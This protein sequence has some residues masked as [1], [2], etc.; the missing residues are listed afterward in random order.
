MDK[1]PLLDAV[2]RNGVGSSTVGAGGGP[3]PVWSAI[4]LE[5]WYVM[6]KKVKYVVLSLWLKM[7]D[8][9]ALIICSSTQILHHEWRP[10]RN[11][12]LHCAQSCVLNDINLV[13]DE[14]VGPMN[15]PDSLGSVE[16]QNYHVIVLRR[17]GQYVLDKDAC[18]REGSA[19]FPWAG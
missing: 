2:V 10:Q 5:S 7:E 4:T 1:A 14:F 11:G 17:S 19:R 12:Q 3:Q 8:F 13:I 16:F 6:E 9:I 15:V 18:P